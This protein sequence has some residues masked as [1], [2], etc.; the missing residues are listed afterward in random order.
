[1]SFLNKQ[2]QPLRLEWALFL[3]K[4]LYAEM[5]FVNPNVPTD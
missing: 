5:P 2:S 1:M 3:E 4:V